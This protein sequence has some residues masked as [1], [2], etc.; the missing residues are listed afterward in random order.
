[1][2]KIDMEGFANMLIALWESVGRTRAMPADWHKK[3]LFP[4]QKA[5]DRSVPENYRPISLLSHFSKTIE[6]SIDLA[7]K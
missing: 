1:M 6:K 3:I 7:I 4:I 5:G 2:M